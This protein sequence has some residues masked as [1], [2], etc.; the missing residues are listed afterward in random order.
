M[1]ELRTESKFARP[2]FRLAPE[3]G[4]AKQPASGGRGKLLMD[5]QSMNAMPMI[6]AC[7]TSER[8]DGPRIFP[9]SK[10]WR[11]S[12]GAGNAR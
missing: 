7:S 1:D 8:P 12:P 4:A 2:E 10:C 9:T 3:W 6:H 11:L 5:V